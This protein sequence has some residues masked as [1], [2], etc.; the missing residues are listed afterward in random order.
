MNLVMIYRN[1]EKELKSWCCRY[2]KPV[3]I[4]MMGADFSEWWPNVQ[5]AF[6]EVRPDL[7]KAIMDRS[8]TTED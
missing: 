7:M 5:K 6:N 1:K 8:V 4:D 2:G 3:V